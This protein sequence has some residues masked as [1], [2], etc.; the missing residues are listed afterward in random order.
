MNANDIKF[1]CSSLGYIMT[2]PRSKS[3]TLSETCK[4]HLVDCFVSA[5]YNRREEITGKHLDK[6]N[7]R[8]EDSITL[9][10]RVSKRFYT[11]NDIRLTNDFISGELDLFIGKSIYEA[12]ETIDTKTSW[13]AHTFHRAK[14]KELDNM[15]YWQGQ[16]YMALSGAKKHTVAYCLVNGTDKAINDEKRL[17]AYSMGIIDTTVDNPEYKSKCKQIEIN[18]IFDIEAFKNEY[19]WFEFDND[20][21]DWKFDIPMDERLFLFQFE[22]NDEDIKK[23]YQRISDCRDYMDKYLF[24]NKIEELLK[25]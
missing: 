18:H 14:N 23:L 21:T 17:L 24:K 3:E 10:S 16:G 25:A 1:R 9:L 2:N 4:T 12:E 6:G 22:R 8:E 19:P 11:K 7:A 20:L 15:Y 5:K 13:S